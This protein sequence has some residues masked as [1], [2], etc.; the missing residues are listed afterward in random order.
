VVIY[1]AASGVGTASLQI[2]KLMGYEPYAVVSGASKGELVKK[3]GAKAVVHYLDNENWDD[4]LLVKG[5]GKGFDAVLDCVGPKNANATMKLLL[6][7]GRWVFYG[8][9]SG[10]KGELNFGQLISKRIKIVSTTLKTRKK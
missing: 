9:L 8:T 3:L 7:D 2:C 10:I 6:V 5:G 1:A 4:E